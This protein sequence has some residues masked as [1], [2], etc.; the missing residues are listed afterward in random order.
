MW[1]DTDDL[2]PSRRQPNEEKDV[3]SHKAQTGPDFSREEVGRREHFHVRSYEF[4]PRRRFLPFRRRRDTVTLQHVPD[5]LVA[6]LVSQICKR[7]GDT[8]ISP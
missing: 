6:H 7:P 8:I 1:R 5:R 2:N 3:I 4:F